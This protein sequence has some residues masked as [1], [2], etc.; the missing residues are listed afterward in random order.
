M[1][2][3]PNSKINARDVI[4]VRIPV[5]YASINQINENVNKEN[6]AT[7]VNLPLCTIN[8]NS[9]EIQNNRLRLTTHSS[10]S[11]GM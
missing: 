10:G 6:H 2:I 11:A 9:A 5:E 3:L 7:E 4:M 1:K 8:L